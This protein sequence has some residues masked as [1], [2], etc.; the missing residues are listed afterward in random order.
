MKNGTA[1]KAALAALPAAPKGAITFPRE[2]QTTAAENARVAGLGLG[3]RRVSSVTHP[4][5]PPFAARGTRDRRRRRTRRSARRRGWGWCR[6]ASTRSLFLGVPALAVVVGAFRSPVGSLDVE[7]HLHRHPR[8]LRPRIR[9]Q[10]RAGAAD[11][12]HPRDHR[13]A[14]GQRRP[15]HRGAASCGGS[16]RPP[17]ASSPSSAASPW[18]SS[19]SPASGPPA[20]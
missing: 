2:A 5:D 14:G 4:A 18:P 19:S 20:W 8:G 9:D 11:V 17:R 13:P 16:S 7:Q 12:D 6:S 3:Y 1:N 10:H 15:H